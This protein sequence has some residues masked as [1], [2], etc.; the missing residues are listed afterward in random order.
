VREAYTQQKEI[1][2]LMTPNGLP[3]GFFPSDKQEV[4]MFIAL[5]VGLDVV[6][7]GARGGAWERSACC[8]GA[9]ATRCARV[10]ACFAVRRKAHT[11]FLPAPLCPPLSLQQT[12]ARRW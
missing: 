1:C 10:R 6:W 4:A 8:V 5:R 2:G 12:A 7:H 3:A 11:T 9:S